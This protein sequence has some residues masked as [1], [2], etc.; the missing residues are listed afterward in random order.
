MET[1]NYWMIAIGVALMI[2]GGWQVTSIKRSTTKDEGHL[3]LFGFLDFK[4]KSFGSLAFVLG[5]VLTVLSQFPSLITPASRREKVE[6]PVNVN[7]SGDG[8]IGVGK[9]E[10]SS[11][12][13]QQNYVGPKK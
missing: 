1:T 11:A 13:I 12:T 9:I 3:K 7:I 5:V 6:A 4:F 10:N 2:F 8:N